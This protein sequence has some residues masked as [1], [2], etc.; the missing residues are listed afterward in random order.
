MQFEK[1]L[2][3]IPFLRYLVPF[4]IGIYLYTFLQLK[5]NSEF[6]LYVTGGV[7]LILYILFRN[8]INKPSIAW[9]NGI[10]INILLVMGGFLLT[11]TRYQ[12][13][14]Y[15]SDS[16]SEQTSIAYISEVP[17][18]SGNHNKYLATMCMYKTDSGWIKTSGKVILFLPKNDNCA[19]LTI[20]S[21]IIFQAKLRPYSKKGNPEEFNYQQYFL[22]KDIYGY[23]YMGEKNWINLNKIVNS[24]RLYSIRVREYLLAMYRKYGIKDD[25]YALL[26]ALT[27]GDKSELDSRLYKVFAKSGAMHI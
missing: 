22:N 12:L 10:I 1:E 16:D 6:V 14:D 25:E 5:I 9:L 2:N 18:T 11:N 15:I 13:P 21:S 8:K 19:K 24:P 27:L 20:G 4:I 3:K 23:A 26:A 7:L 17:V